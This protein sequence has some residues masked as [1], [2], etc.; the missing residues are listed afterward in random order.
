MASNQLIAQVNSDGTVSPGQN[1]RSSV[2]FK[3]TLPDGATDLQYGVINSP[4]T[5]SVTFNVMQDISLGRDPVVASGKT[6]NSFSSPS[7]YPN[8]GSFYIANPT[9]N[10]GTPPPP[11]TVQLFAVFPS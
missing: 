9:N 11:F 1:N 4:N 2:D 8:G 5:S 7:D 10:P 3:F 6:N